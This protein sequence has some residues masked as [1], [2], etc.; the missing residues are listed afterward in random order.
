MHPVC[1]HPGLPPQFQART[2]TSTKMWS[3]D[4]WVNGPW[5]EY[6]AAFEIFTDDVIPNMFGA[7][8]ADGRSI[9]PCR[10]HGGHWDEN[11]GVNAEPGEPVVF[12]VWVF[13]AHN[14][15]KLGM[16]RREA[17]LFNQSYIRQYLLGLPPSESASQW[18]D[19]NRLYSIMFN[20]GQ[21]ISFPGPHR[22][23]K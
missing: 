15:Y 13:Y 4:V 14:E 19:R 20:L 16:W 2:S 10:V 7:L 1:Q 8:Q 22:L 3:P 9:K 23:K 21:S 11:I 5:P 18:E 12:D 6:E 17:I